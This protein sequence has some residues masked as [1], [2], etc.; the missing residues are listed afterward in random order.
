MAIT[1]EEA[2]KK[3]CEQFTYLKNSRDLTYRD[4]ENGAGVQHSCISYWLSGKGL[5]NGFAIVK[6]CDYF[7]VTADYLLGR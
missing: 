2:S 1:K 7:G 3:F 6:L 5:P 4:I